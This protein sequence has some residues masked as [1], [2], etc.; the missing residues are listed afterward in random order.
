MGNTAATGAILVVLITAL[1]PVS[2]A[3][4]NPA[5]TL[6][7]AFRRDILPLEALMYAAVQI[8]GGVLGTVVAHLMFEQSALQVSETARTGPAQWLA[9]AVATFG[10]VATIL[11]VSGFAPRRCHRSLVSTSPRPTGLPRRR[12]SPIRQSRLLEV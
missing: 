4:F 1:G 9:E 3:H 7:F 6:A 2:G 12:L 8:S 5:V 11:R 10:L